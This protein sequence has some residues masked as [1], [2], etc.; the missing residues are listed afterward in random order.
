MIQD[1]IKSLS[2][3]EIVVIAQ[4][5]SNNEVPLE[6]VIKQLIAKSNHNEVLSTEDEVV[7]LET[8]SLELAQRLNDS[9]LKQ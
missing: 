7:I 1:I 5:L 8:L 9:H 4:E 3:T 2:D 6:Y